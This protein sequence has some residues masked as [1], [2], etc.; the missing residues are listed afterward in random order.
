[1]NRSLGVPHFQVNNLIE[2]GLLG[3]I[4]ISGYA[5][6]RSLSDEGEN[7]RLRAL[8]IQERRRLLSEKR[9]FSQS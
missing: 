5:F 6:S 7:A 8:K 9:R 3:W 4:A 2:I 1:M